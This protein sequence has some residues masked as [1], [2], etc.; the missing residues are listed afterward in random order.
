MSLR[1]IRLLSLGLFACLLSLPLAASPDASKISGIVVDPAG[2]PQMGATVVV[3]SEQLSAWSP[4]QVLT[5]GHGHFSTDLLPAGQ[6]SIQ[7][8]LAGF[9]P[10]IERHIQVDSQHATL[11]QVVMGSVF[12]SL[13]NLRRQPNQPASEADDWSWVLRTSASTR[14]VLRWQDDSEHFCGISRAI[15]N[16]W[17]FS[18]PPLRA[19]RIQL[20]GGSSGIVIECREFAR[21]LFR[22]RSER[23]HLGPFVDGRAGEP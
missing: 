1:A 18:G 15:A 3:S 5:N 9:L 19:I 11:L 12:A 23:G 14:P 22:L 7:V 2:T 21:D 16:F 10:A 13:D 8:T 20:G 4:V 17:F 6:Y